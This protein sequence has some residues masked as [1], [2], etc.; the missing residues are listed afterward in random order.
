MLF[1]VFL[2]MLFS[3]QKDE[4]YDENQEQSKSIKIKHVSIK[5]IMSKTEHKN[6]RKTFSHF[7]EKNKLKNDENTQ[8]KMTY[9]QGFGIYID[10]ENG[11]FIEKDGVQSYTFRIRRNDAEDKLEN[12]VFKNNLNG[13][14]ETI[15]TT[16]DITYTEID[17]LGEQ[18]I[19]NRDV[20]YTTYDY[21]TEGIPSLNCIQ[22]WAFLMVPPDEGN[23]TG[24]SIEYVGIW[25]LQG[26]NCGYIGGGGSSG[27]NPTGS[28]GSNNNS[29]GSS[30]YNSGSSSGSGNQNSTPINTTPITKGKNKTANPYPHLVDL[31]DSQKYNLNYYINN[32]ILKYNN[33][34]KNEVSYSFKRQTLA[35]G[36]INYTAD[37]NE[38][39][40]TSVKI[41]T[42][43]HNSVIHL[44][45][46]KSETAGSIFSFQDMRALN[47]LYN[48][49]HIYSQEDNSI[50]LLLLCPDPLNNENH[51]VY[52]LTV[53]NNILLNDAIT[54]EWNSTKW[55]SY[56]DIDKR[57]RYIQDDLAYKYIANKDNLEA[58][59]LQYFSNYGISLYKL[60]NNVWNQLGL[61]TNG[62]I[63]TLPNN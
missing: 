10:E 11:I 59:F 47:S 63:V 33:G 46:K 2:T 3:C 1:F 58:F 18:A 29:P 15:I 52:A 23:N 27:G 40:P 44:H 49:A 55:A 51:N 19:R 50:A 17:I 28:V 24:G 34:E 14:F 60:E 53:K 7:K 31:L 42:G 26:L 54:N 39:T 30:S 48:D 57:L 25:V 41:L 43:T 32:L 6:V 8:S 56:T 16:Y 13:D 35:D 9:N 38:G 61:T 22:I 20:L 36:T 5:D 4:L 21:E 37:Y 62:T 45:P 12:I